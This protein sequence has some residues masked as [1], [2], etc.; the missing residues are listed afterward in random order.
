MFGFRS[1]LLMGAAFAALGSPALAQQAQ[2]TS[3]TQVEEV[4]VTAE[5][6]SES[7]QK[8]PLAITALSGA[9]LARQGAD[10]FEDI[11]LMAPSVTFQNNGSTEDKVIMRGITAGSFF[12]AQT[13]ATGYYLNDIPLTSSFTSGGTDLKLF[14][15]NRVEVLRGPQGTLYGAGAMGGAIRVITNQPN[16]NAYHAEVE[17]TGADVA[18]RAADFDVNG[19]LNIPIINDQLALR[20]V[21]TYRDDGGYIKDPT[22]GTNAAN[23][24]HVFGAR[25]ALEW[26]PTD[27]FTA[28][29]TGIYQNDKDDG[30]S[31]IDTNAN[32]KP[33][34]GDLTE[35]SLYAEPGSATTAAVNLAFKYQLSGATLESSTTYSHNTTDFVEDDTL[36]IG[37][38]L[39]NPV[40]GTPGYTSALPDDDHSFVQEIRLVSSQPGPLKWVVGA[41]YQND[42][43]V[44]YRRD[45]LDPTS[46]LG[47]LGIIPL[48]YHTETKRQ[49]FAVFGE[50]TYTFWQNW[51][52]TVG[53]RYSYVPTSYDADLYGLLVAPFTT[54]ATA[55]NPGVAKATS[56][57]VSP[58][59]EITYHPSSQSLIYVEAAKGFRPGSPNSA[60]P[61][62]PAT[63]APDYLWDYE[64]GGKSSWLDGR[65]TVDGALYYIDWKNIQVVASTPAN[66]VAPTPPNVP[67]LGNIGSAVSKGA[68]LEIQARPTEALMF[69][70]S[71]AY[72]DATYTA[73]NAQIGITNGERI[74]TVPR[75][76]GSAAVDYHWP[77][78]AA[79]NGFAHFDV[80]YESDKPNGLAST[81]KGVYIPAYSLGNLRIGADFAEG[82][83]VT[84]FANNLWD[85]RDVSEIVTSSLCLTTNTATC[86]GLATGTPAKFRE[87]IGQPRTLGATVSKK[88]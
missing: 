83:T 46:V 69:S 32:N 50:S 40:F 29:L 65:L 9:R 7:V 8:V 41:Y 86:P 34:Y 17:V 47:S 64:V 45:R 58:K 67:Y 78:T 72:T 52:A 28:T 48:D 59:F 5:K 82:T 68:E 49:T 54:P 39:S 11:A 77:I 57:D 87:V 20:T 85:T 4:V 76:S 19:M 35:H 36:A 30:L 31:I 23:A 81:D 66:A 75:F 6:R 79:I 16:L 10:K 71:G 1:A 3:S 22:L 12:E 24:S 63:L 27:K 15:V 61:G 13:A 37:V 51:D 56:T 84:L 62:T 21:L 43:L 26:Q 44:V 70:L 88:F 60:I 25:S 74:P 73:S 38:L 80:R 55:I 42:D 53:L 14:D 2:T 33:I 18:S